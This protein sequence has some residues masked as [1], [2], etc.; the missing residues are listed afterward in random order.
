M[1]A[2]CV[3]LPEDLF[4]SHAIAYSCEGTSLNDIVLSHT[5]LFTIN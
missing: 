2:W 5:L 3:S 1:L 4:M